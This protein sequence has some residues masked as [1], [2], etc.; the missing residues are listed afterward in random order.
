MLC[1]L[2]LNSFD[3]TPVHWY[4][5]E[6]HRLALNPRFG[7]GKGAP[8]FPRWKR[9]I[10]TQSVD[11]W[12]LIQDTDDENRLHG[13]CHMYIAEFQHLLE[14]CTFSDQISHIATRM[15]F[16]N[17]LLLIFIW[18]VKYPD[19]SVLCQIFGTSTTVV[20]SI[21][22]NT[23]PYLVDHFIQFIPGRLSGT[24]PTSHLSPLIKCVI[25]ATIHP[26]RR[27]SI[28]QYLYYNGNYET[29]GILTHLLVDFDANIIALSTNVLGHMHDATSAR[30]NTHFKEIMTGCYALGDPGYGGVPYVV[31]GFKSNQVHTEADRTFDR[32]SRSEQVVV[33]HVN[34]FLKQVEVL[35]KRSKFEHEISMLVS[36]VFIVCGWYNFSKQAFNKF[37]YN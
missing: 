27:P 1:L 19:Y 33:E 24:E 23:L 32:I 7:R 30:H 18:L 29:H 28:D 25:D 20:S 11:L 37:S 16:A 13:L 2:I 5:L 22:H 36:A 26:I 17:K 35:S 8:G 21:L 12:Q 34:A 31:A 6:H 9:R 14:T 15:T 3:D 4:G 10:K